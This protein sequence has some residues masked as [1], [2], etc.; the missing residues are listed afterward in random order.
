[1]TAPDSW[2][3]LSRKH[4]HDGMP[5]AYR[6]ALPPPPLRGRHSQLKHYSL[7]PYAD[8]GSWLKALVAREETG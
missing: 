2:D 3:D 4:S 1:M 6:R 8:E 7:L 5:V